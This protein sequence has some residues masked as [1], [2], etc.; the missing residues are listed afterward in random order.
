MINPSDLLDL[1]FGEEQRALKTTDFRSCYPRFTFFTSNW[2]TGYVRQVP[3]ELNA[4]VSAW[5]LT[6]NKGSFE[7]ARRD[8]PSAR[9]VFLDSGALSPLWVIERG[10][11]DMT[12]LHD[13]LGRQS[14]LVEI[15]WDLFTAGVLNGVAACLDMPCVPGLL[16][17]VGMSTQEAVAFTIRNATDWHAVELPPGWRPVYV[18]QGWT[19]QDYAT[20]MHA[21]EDLGIMNDVRAGKAW[22]AVGSTL[23]RRPPSLYTVHAHARKL[24]G[25]GHIHALGIARPDS[26]AYMAR[27]GWVNSADASSSAASVI[28]NRG[29]YRVA[30]P[31]PTYLCH[32]LFAAS[33]QY[34]EA[35]LADALATADGEEIY[36]QEALL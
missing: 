1:D 16:D 34:E 23:V 15:A 29:P 22:L 10:K 30:G 12:L 18:A 20:C 35:L 32:A 33:A 28:Y 24:L 14:T 8:L 4:L 6:Q 26:L 27:R 5:N 7:D 11:G 17:K 31:R 2:L 19:V 21:Y 25:K 3:G 36:E 9:S 13:W